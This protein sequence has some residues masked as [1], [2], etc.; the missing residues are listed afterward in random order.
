[1]TWSIGNY[2]F[3]MVLT[4]EVPK[5]IEK[6]LPDT[7][8]KMASQGVDLGQVDYWAVHPGGRAILDAVQ[9]VTGI[10]DVAITPSLETLRDYGNMSSATIWFVLKRLLTQP[11]ARPSQGIMMAF[12]PGLTIESGLLT[13]HHPAQEKD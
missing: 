9:R 12:G 10:A 3:D 7:L 2:G 4:P 8:D 11:A 6:Y 5:L 1:M 13:C